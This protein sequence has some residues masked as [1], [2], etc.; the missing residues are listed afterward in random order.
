[1]P[2]SFSLNLLAKSFEMTSAR[3]TTSIGTPARFATCV[4][5]DDVAMPS[6]SLYKNTSY[7]KI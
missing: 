7:G 6:I 2:S 1:L 3:S 5:K 4:P